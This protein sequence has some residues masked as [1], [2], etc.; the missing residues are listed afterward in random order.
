MIQATVYLPCPNC[1]E[2]G[3]KATYYQEELDCLESIECDCG[4]VLNLDGQTTSEALAMWDKGLER[5][6]EDFIA[7]AHQTQPTQ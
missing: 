7:N 4:T 6:P 5:T 2:T 1:K 3:A